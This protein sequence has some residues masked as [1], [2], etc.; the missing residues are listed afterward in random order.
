MRI[1][2]LHLLE[3]SSRSHWAIASHSGQL[4]CIT[5]HILIGNCF[6]TVDQLHHWLMYINNLLLG[7][8]KGMA[9][10]VI[11]TWYLFGISS[12]FIL[13][14]DWINSGLHVR[15][16]CMHLKTNGVYFACLRMLRKWEGS[17]LSL[18]QNWEFSIFHVTW[19]QIR[20]YRG[21]RIYVMLLHPFI[22]GT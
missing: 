18:C 12:D 19:N 17:E 4:D 3:L 21:N 7:L 13:E 14:L 1:F 6:H 22:W 2:H 16:E 9:K 5:S 8:R 15:N 11:G 10:L 20:L